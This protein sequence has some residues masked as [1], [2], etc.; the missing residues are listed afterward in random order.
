MYSPV[1][2]KNVAQFPFHI[3]WTITVTTVLCKVNFYISKCVI[4]KKFLI[5]KRIIFYWL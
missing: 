2:M 3:V 5:E 1:K 4:G